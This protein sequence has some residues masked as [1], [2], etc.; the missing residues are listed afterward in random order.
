M[1]KMIVSK[2]NDRVIGIHAIGDDMPEI[3]QLAAVAIRAGAKKSDFDTTMGIH[4]TAAEEM[5]TMK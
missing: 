5:V 2:H 4:P 3:I 1:V